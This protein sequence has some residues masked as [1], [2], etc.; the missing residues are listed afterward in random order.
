MRIDIVS[1]GMYTYGSLVLGGI[2]RDRGHAVKITK[3]LE[4]QGEVTLLS[5]FSTLQL[6]DPKIKKFVAGR[7]K[8]YVGGPV[9]LCPEMVLGELD[10]KA[11]GC[12]RRRGHRG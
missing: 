4:S 1:P 6:L 10:A 7:E 8:V 11:V 9:G 5:L 2:L 12:G 3:R